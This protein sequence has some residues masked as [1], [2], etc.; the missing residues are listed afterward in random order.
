MINIMN[1]LSIDYGE[2]RIGFAIGDSERKIP[3]PLQVIQN[4]SIP[5]IIDEIKKIV[6]SYNVEKIVIGI[7]LN[8]D[9]SIGDQSYKV[10]DFSLIIEKEL[11]IDVIGVDE[12]FSSVDAEKILLDQDLSRKKRKKVIDALA[13]SIIL[14][15]YFEND[16]VVNI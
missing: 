16:E 13:A 7:P 1:I 9:S 11:N 2:K 12:R 15:R 6:I 5:F 8:E 4:N 14:Q 10:K 3:N